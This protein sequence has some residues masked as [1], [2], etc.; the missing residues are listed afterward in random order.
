M[1][2]VITSFPHHKHNG[3]GN[4]ID[5]HMVSLGEVLDEIQKRILAGWEY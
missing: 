1:S 4:I 3:N 2:Q 5:S